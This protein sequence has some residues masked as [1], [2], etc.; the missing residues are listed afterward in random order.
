[1]NVKPVSGFLITQYP[2]HKN[3][4]LTKGVFIST[5]LLSL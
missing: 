4:Q 3:Q 2:A 1:M 5:P